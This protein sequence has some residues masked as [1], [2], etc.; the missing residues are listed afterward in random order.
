MNENIELQQDALQTAISRSG[1]KVYF[2]DFQ[3]RRPT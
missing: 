2:G 1:R 3:R